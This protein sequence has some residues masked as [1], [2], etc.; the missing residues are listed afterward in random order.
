M[1]LKEE[2]INV[3]MQFKSWDG[4]DL[5]KLANSLFNLTK[6]CFLEFEE[7]RKDYILLCT[8]ALQL[9]SS[10]F[11]TKMFANFVTKTESSLPKG[12]INNFGE[13]L[14]SL[15]NTIDNRAEAINVLINLLVVAYEN[16]LLLKME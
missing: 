12:K 5:E 2:I 9:I 1:V 14:I 10:F 3:G 16:D 4:Q 13:Q 6:K 7:T 8:V 11:V 15:G